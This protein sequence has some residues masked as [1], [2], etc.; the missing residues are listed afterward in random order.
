ML[1]VIIIVTFKL[2]VNLQYQCRIMLLTIYVISPIFNTANIN[3][4]I[5]FIIINL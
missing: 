5:Y 2:Q 1:F 4:T 3:S